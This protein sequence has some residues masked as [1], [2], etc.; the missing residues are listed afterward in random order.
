L[1]T[2]LTLAVEYNPDVTD[3]ESLATALDRL[4]TTACST[5]GILEECGSPTIGA[6]F[7][8]PPSEPDPGNSPTAPCECEAPGFFH[9]GV[10]GILAHRDDAGHVAPDSR[11]ERCDLCRR[12]PND[13]AAQARL[14]ELGMMPQAGPSRYVLYDFDADE[15][16]TTTIY[17]DRGEAINDA[18]QFDNVIVMALPVPSHSDNTQETP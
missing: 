13:A 15:L 2:Q 14:V 3:P 1:K 5:P 17:A 6:V 11:V 12:Y 16:A 10:P 18:S 4:L 7:V 9:S 8:V